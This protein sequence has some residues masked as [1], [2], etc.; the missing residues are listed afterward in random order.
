MEENT[1]NK[2]VENKVVEN[3]RPH[4]PVSRGPMSSGRP[5]RFIRRKVCRFCVDKV[6]KVDYKDINRLKKFVTDRGKIIPRRITGTCARHQRQ[7]TE[8]IQR[9]RYIALLPYTAE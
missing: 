1:Q 6:D 8:G 7:V 2:P 4:A 3:V 5:Q 9:A